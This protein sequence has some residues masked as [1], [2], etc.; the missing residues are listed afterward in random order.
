MHLVH[1]FLRLYSSEKVMDMI[2]PCEDFYD[3][4]DQYNKRLGG[5]TLP[6]REGQ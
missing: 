1:G 2:V 5:E 4:L 6:Y 3:T